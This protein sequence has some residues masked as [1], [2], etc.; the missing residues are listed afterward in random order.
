MTKQN[1]WVLE[2]CLK[3]SECILEREMVDESLDID[4]DIDNNI[5]K[6][7]SKQS[8]GNHEWD[9]EPV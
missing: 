7:R 5:A 6:R 2:G 8:P 9:N 1:Y 3:K 4:I